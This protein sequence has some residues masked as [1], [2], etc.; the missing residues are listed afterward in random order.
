MAFGKWPLGQATLAT[1]AA[2]RA[3]RRTLRGSRVPWCV[4]SAPADQTVPSDSPVPPASAEL[5]RYLTASGGVSVKVLTATE[6]VRH[7]T[8]LHGGMSHVAKHALGR[9]LMAN[10]LLTAGKD[11]GETVQLK[12]Q[13]GGP[14][15]LVCTEAVTGEDGVV[16]ARGFVEHK[17]YEHPGDE[18]AAGFVGACVG[19]EGYLEVRRRHPS[20]KEGYTGVVGLRSGE[21]GD[22]VALYLLT[23]EQVRSVVGVGVALHPVTG[24]VTAA[25]GFLCS[26]LPG[27]SDGEL[28]ALEANVL[29]LPPPSELA[30][31]LP[32]AA[33]RRLMRGLEGEASEGGAMSL[34]SRWTESV[35][36]RCGCGAR[37]TARALL[38][39]T[40]GCQGGTDGLAPE[41]AADV[42]C[43]WC[44]KCTAMT[45][46]DIEREM[47]EFARSS[48]S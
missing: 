1:L 6:L 22:D 37:D 23:S 2:R 12:L 39:A 11:T 43:E 9:A 32:G 31:L 15:G 3:P 45:P 25:A 14:L 34:A 7:A 28:D 26:A 38:A 16:S 48:E 46:L 10:I 27:C 40:P 47:A 21:V 8:D 36:L 41:F 17:G 4:F 19:R 13:G 42:T 35:E 33:A 44:G 5:V 30:R 18:G 20:W 24:E 29:A